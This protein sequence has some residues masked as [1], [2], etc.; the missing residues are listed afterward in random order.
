[1]T[2][3]YLEL[4]AIDPNDTSQRW[5]VG[6]HRSLYESRQKHGH[7]RSLARIILVHEVISEGVAQIYSGWSRPDKSDCH[8]Y[9]GF[10]PRDYKSLTIDT[11][12]PKNMAFLVFVLPDGTIDE[13]TWRPI[14][15]QS[16][17]LQG[18]KGEL[19]WS[20]NQK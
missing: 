8:V 12:A 1:M 3:W 15:R 2:Q 5:K 16:G 9:V 11:P 14:D 4:E 17:E 13:W 20:R 10:P 6:I 18:V 7:E 19:I